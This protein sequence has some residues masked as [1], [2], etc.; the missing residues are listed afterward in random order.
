MPFTK[1]A[2]AVTIEA[3]HFGYRRNPVRNFSSVA[4]K[5]G[6]RLHDR[7]G[8]GLMMVS[9]GLQRVPRRRAERRRVKVVVAQTASRQAIHRG[10]INRPTKRCGRA[11]AHV[12]DQYNDNVRCTLGRL[13]VEQWRCLDIANVELLELGRI[14]LGNGKVGSVYLEGLHTG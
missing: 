3:H 14:R 13:N 8:I 5:S 9:T 1:G 10:R 2:R 4:R 6:R 11:E 12:I 7:A